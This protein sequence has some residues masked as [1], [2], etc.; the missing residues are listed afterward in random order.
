KEE[1]GDGEEVKLGNEKFL[2]IHP[3][4]KKFL[5]E[6]PS[7]DENSSVETISEKKLDLSNQGLRSIPESV[8][9]DRDL[10]SLDLSM[11]QLRTIPKSISQLSNLTE[12]D[13]SMNQLRTIPKSISQLSNLKELNLSGNQLITIP[14]SISQ[15]SNLTVL[16]LSMNE[17]ITIPESISQLSNLIRLNLEGNPLETI[18]STEAIIF[19][20][21]NR[22][23]IMQLELI[24]Q[25]L[26]QQFDSI[27][28]KRAFLQLAGIDDY[29]INGR[30]FNLPPHQFI[31]E[32]VADLKDYRISHRMPYYHP[33]LLIIDH[34]INQPIA[35]FYYL[36]DLDIE[37]LAMFRKRGDLQIQKYL[38]S[39]MP[40]TRI[41]SY[42]SQEN[43]I[44]IKRLLENI[45]I[46][47]DGIAGRKAIFKNAG[48]AQ[49]FIAGLDF[50][51]NIYEFITILVS[52]FKDYP[53]SSQRLDYH[54]LIA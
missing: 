12:L 27:S 41:F 45:L 22:D 40:N 11:N 35:K 48:F 43:L 36:D 17:L 4:I 24:F 39:K 8:F 20:I 2:L 16:D 7:E 5:A 32:L 50:N 51:L 31:T 44:K 14:E 52:K 54:P 46:N 23:N 53:V 30:Y 6:F 33:L 49:Y 47:I 29:F 15:L 18:N 37:Y 13:L 9:E 28:R 19:S 21:L 10:T 1:F 3:V 26:F 34:V 25:R 38:Q 42:L